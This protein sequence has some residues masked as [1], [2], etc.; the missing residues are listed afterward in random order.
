MRRPISMSPPRP[1]HMLPLCILP[2]LQAKLADAVRQ[3][4]HRQ[5]VLHRAH[6]QRVLNHIRQHLQGSAND[7]SIPI[8]R[9][10][11]HQ[12]CG[13]HELACLGSH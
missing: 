10:H 13:E 1:S 9:F 2:P 7:I 4:G 6:L 12:R 5:P 11:L 8:L 3:V